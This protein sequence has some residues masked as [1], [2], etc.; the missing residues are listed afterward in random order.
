MSAWLEIARRKRLAALGAGVGL[1]LGA[2]V[3]WS[4]FIPHR[5]LI[6]EAIRK[7][8]Y[9]A[10][11]AEL[12]AWYPSVP[13]AENV[14]LVYTN[15]FGLLTNLAGTNARFMSWLPPIGQSVSPEDG[16]DLK[17]MLVENEPALRLLYAVPATGRSRYPIHLADGPSTEL[18]HLM[19]LKQAVSLL[20]AEALLRASDGDAEGATQAFLAAGRLAESLSEEPI[21]LSQFVRYADWAILLP[22]LERALSLTPFTEAQLASLQ[23]TVEGAE[24]PQ[25]AVRAMA[26]KRAMNLSVFS[27]RE[28]MEVVFKAG[29]GSGSRSD[30][31]LT[32]ASVSLYRVTGLLGKDKAFYFD[33][34]GRHVAALELPYPDR[35]AAEAQLATLTNMPGRL[36]IFSR[37]LLPSLGKAPAGDADHVAL[38]RVAATALAIERFRVA[39][40]NALP[41]NLEQLMPACCMAVPA[42]PYDGKPLRYKPHG[43]SYAVYSVGSDGH[44]DGG[45]VWGSN[46]LKVPQDVAFVVKH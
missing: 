18:S 20:S 24:Q 38:V 43:A 19:K 16:R 39:H 10:S 9:P 41:E 5:D 15:A 25:A 29:Q 33:R 12:D 30:K 42:D 7:Q 13:A 26:G 36:Y 21:L 46:Y 23:K 11:L 32:A 37:M 34:I 35:F 44:D 31:L 27:S 2:W 45:V 4:L 3:L 14:A 8:G 6:A 22:R 17:A 40:S 1:L 28:I